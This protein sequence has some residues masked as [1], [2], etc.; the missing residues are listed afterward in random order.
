MKVAIHQPNY[1]PWCGYFAKIRECDA[2]IIL[3]D[4][5]MP[6]GRSYVSRTKIRSNVESK[7]LT[8]PTKVHDDPVIA[9]VILAEENWAKKHLATLRHTYSKAPHFAEVM[10]I[11]EPVYGFAGVKLGQVNRCFISAILDYLE[12][13]RPTCLSSSLDVQSASDDRLIELILKVGGTHYISGRG[14]ANYQ[15]PDKFRDAGIGLEVNEYAPLPYDAPHFPFVPGLSIVDAL[16][17]KGRKARDLL[18]YKS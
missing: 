7:W 14:G 15:N 9:D 1:L 4:V 8:A 12:L 5:Q 17:I 16:F 3:D 10:A 2:F 13:E 6:R 18:H 11:L